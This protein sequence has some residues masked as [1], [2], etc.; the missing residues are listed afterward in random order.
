M[1]V[2]EDAAERIWETFQESPKTAAAVFELRNRHINGEMDEGGIWGTGYA[3]SLGSSAR[4]PPKRWPLRQHAAFLKLHALVGSGQV[5]YT[6][7]STGGMP[8]PDADRDGNAAMLA[9]TFP[10]FKATLN[11]EQNGAGFDG[12]LRW[13]DPLMI[14]RPTGEFFYGSDCKHA[15]QTILAYPTTR[16]PGWAPLEVGDSWPSRT[17]MHLWQY[18][19]VARWPYGS[20]LIWLFLNYG[21]GYDR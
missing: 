11:R 15:G 6:M 2:H 16:E 9:K 19:A 5:A 17:L 3:D 20:K 18:R 12:S 7:I 13:G 8:G 14:S 1:T 21:W 10:P 4:F